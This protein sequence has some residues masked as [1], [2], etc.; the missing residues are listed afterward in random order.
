MPS[1]PP[2]TQK[3]LKARLHNTCDNASVRMLKKMRV[4]RTHTNPNSAE[5]SSV[6]RS[7]PTMQSSMDC[8]PRSRTMNATV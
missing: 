7:P 3:N 4:C 1:V 2:V 5:M 8:A 6:P